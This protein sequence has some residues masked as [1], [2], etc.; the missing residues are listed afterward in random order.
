MPITQRQKRWL[1]KRVHHLKPVVILGQAGLTDAVL[2]EIDG[3][4]DHHELIKVKVNAG[5]RDA[6]DAAVAMIAERTGSDFVDRV[7]NMAAFFR[8]NPQKRTPMRLPEP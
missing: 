6:R 4:L 1:K 3:A 2:A 7:G 5:D 8:A